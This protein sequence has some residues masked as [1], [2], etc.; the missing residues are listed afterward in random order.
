[1]VPLIRMRQ[2][3]KDFSNL[4][5]VLLCDYVLGEAEYLLLGQ[6]SHTA[7]SSHTVVVDFYYDDSG[8]LTSQNRTI[9]LFDTSTNSTVTTKQLP[10]NQSQGSIGFECFHFKA[11]GLYQFRIVHEGVN[12]SD[13]ELGSCVLNVTW[14]VFH[15]DLNRT[16]ETAG[17]SLQVGIFITEML[18]S[19]EVNKTLFSLDVQHTNH[20]YEYEKLSTDGDLM[21][22]TSK[23]IILSRS[24]WVEI[25]CTS[26]S[27]QAYVMV[28]LTSLDTNLVISSIGPIDLVQ[29]FGYKLVVTAALICESLVGVHIIPPPCISIHGKI[30]VYKEISRRSGVS[31]ASLA[32][33][34]LYPG[35]DRTEFNCTLFDIGN[36]KYCFEFFVYSSKSHAIPRAKE[37]V[38]IQR[39]IETWS[40]W[41]AWSPCSVK[42]GDGT[43]E[44]HRQCLSSSL[45]KSGC[46]G[47]QKEISSCSLEDC[48]SVMPPSKP[49]PHPMENQRTGNLVTV[50]GISLCL[51]IIV[52]TVLITMWR[53]LCRTQKCSRSV[54]HNSVHTPS[55][56]KNSDEENI[57]QLNPRESFSESS[58]DAVMRKTGEAG[59]ISLAYKHSVKHAEEHAQEQNAPTND[60][61][62]VQK[63]IPPIF[64]YRLAQQQLKEMK[65]K[66]L[67][68]ETK[69]YHV[70]QNPLTDTILDA[71]LLPPLAAGTQEEVTTTTFRIRSPFSEQTSIYPKFQGERPSSRLEF[72]SNPGTAV[73]SPSLKLTRQPHLSYQDTRGG[74]YTNH[75]FR[76]TASFHESKQARPF[77]ERSLSTLSSRQLPAY[78]AR[79]RMLDCSLEERFRPKPRRMDDKLELS[80]D[81][82]LTSVAFSCS[83]HHQTRLATDKPDLI[84][85]QQSGA[86]S[87]KLEPSK[88]RRG[89]QPTY[90][91]SWKRVG[92]ST[93]NTGDHYQR[94]SHG[95]F[96][97]AQYRREKCQSFPRDPEC[98]FYDNTSFG[99]TEAEQRMIDLPGYFGSNEED[100]TS[101]L[102]VEKLVI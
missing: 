87:E 54:R 93:C 99:L 62:S 31:I 86:R 32:E 39:E 70:S 49:S 94:S 3:L 66:G 9:I 72:T 24:Q 27:Q 63:I 56:R 88:N 18:C 7:L 65:K 16:S 1:M 90:R 73:V 19:L 25:G 17:S 48:T 45:A 97:P 61:A 83:R 33:N 76:R 43:R 81:T 77:R 75:T 60:A 96:S 67:T 102:S 5:L 64:S 91:S 74:Y 58:G 71:T 101:T 34:M 35:R 21:K 52:V 28:T 8:N 41:Q 51:V 14:P 38:T 57:C 69:V 80:K 10:T 53:K 84:H 30:A 29:R 42:C 47:T 4:L 13:V 37:C 36:N 46:V 40:L 78:I 22:R 85:D 11:A 26:D 12:S 50:I 6:H 23:E 55:F 44:R 98:A 15:I 20:L 79:A 2:I 89:L 100:E 95:P 59:N 68:E 82:V 92:D